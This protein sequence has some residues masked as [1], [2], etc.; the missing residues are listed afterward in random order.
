ME[1]LNGL[2]IAICQ[3]PVIAGRP[4]FNTDYILAE[5][6]K[7]ENEKVD[8]IVF[9]E[10]AVP[11]YLIGDLYEDESFVGDIISFNEKIV[12]ASGTAA[13][14]FGSLSVEKTK[15][16]E[17]GR[18]RK[19]NSAIV[20]QNGKMIG[21]ATKS[22]QPNYRMF[23]DD[24][25]FY[26]LRK[27][28]N[29]KSCKL[30]ECQRP[31]EIY[32]SLGKVSVGAIL[33][34]DMWHDDYPENPTQNLVD[35]GAKVI[36]NL[37]SSP[38]TW[39]KNRKRHQVVKDLLA[40]ANVP[41]VYVNNVGMQN[42][43]KNIVVFDG[44]STVYNE[45]GERVF[46][47]EPYF[48]GTKSYLLNNQDSAPSN[49]SSDVE[50]QFLALSTAI[51]E[52]TNQLP[53][54]M[55]K[56]VIGLSGG[57]DSA[58]SA[59]LYTYILGPEN[60]FTINM[61]TKFNSKETKAIAEEIATNLGVSYEV[62]PIQSIVD[63]IATSTNAK[64]GTPTYENIQART[65][66][67]VLAAKAQSLGCVFS[68]NWNKIEAAFGYGTLYGDMAGFLA[69][70]GDLTKFDVY[71][72]ANYLNTDVFEKNVIPRE[73]FDIAPSAELS[74]NQK[75]P[76]DYG[77]LNERGY[78]DEMVRAFTEFRRNPEWILEKYIS[79]ELEGELALSKGKIKKL[80]ST[81]ADFVADLERAWRLYTVSYFKRVQGP[82]IPI[83][84]KRAFGF[85]LRESILPIYFTERYEKLKKQLLATK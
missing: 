49:S 13:V 19:Y 38:W 23:D 43:G 28:A 45:V 1:N 35:Q 55:R 69:A 65:R 24:R 85:D 70:L 51:R 15:I 77:R 42:N 16:G 83:V 17:D 59:A 75:D 63:A 60:V 74:T 30:M 29:E 67:E 52:F 21:F 20:A 61:P 73:C 47:I 5:I 10:M 7:A 9:P 37:S 72:L 41:F 40:K 81:D 68:A 48:A 8:L 50:E 78:H 11:G 36:V 18:T 79:G 58:L 22:L 54:D 64:T 66:M 3:M 31:F 33:C 32:T 14:I 4:D 62:V 56:V 39:Q 80:F 57:I 44:S 53:K 84:T 25:H 46:A 27:N 12:R 71:R 26:S 6:K 76:F 2:K 82:P 34:E